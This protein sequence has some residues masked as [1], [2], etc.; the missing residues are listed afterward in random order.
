VPLEDAKLRAALESI[1]ARPT[2]AEAMAVVDVARLAASIDK[3]S[4][5]AELTLVVGISRVLGEMAGIAEVPLSSAKIDEHRLFDISETLVP[6][7]ARELAYAC[8]YLVMMG[9]LTITVE[10]QKLA[11]M[12]G[13]VL[14]IDPSRSGVLARQMEELARAAGA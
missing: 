10:E 8:A 12:L 3:K 6:V 11:A 14:V 4:N 9:D 7:G 13:D 2:E 1:H 5:V